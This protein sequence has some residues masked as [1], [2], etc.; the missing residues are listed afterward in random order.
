MLLQSSFANHIRTRDIFTTMDNKWRIYY[1]VQPI[2]TKNRLI[3]RLLNYL[4]KYLAQ[5]SAADGLYKRRCHPCL[6]H[7]AI[8]PLPSSVSVRMSTFEVRRDISTF[9]IVCSQGHHFTSG[10]SL[11]SDKNGMRRDMYIRSTQRAS[12]GRD[13]GSTSC[14]HHQSSNLSRLRCSSTSLHPLMWQKQGKRQ[15]R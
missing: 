9:H 11:V 6:S 1:M 12:T 15:Q 14:N 7:N 2:E 4:Q 3:W 5:R 10:K 8:E 13:H